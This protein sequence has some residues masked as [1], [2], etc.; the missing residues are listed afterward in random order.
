MGGGAALLGATAV[1]RIGAA[2]PSEKGRAFTFAVLNP[3][4]M[5][6]GA[7][8]CVVMLTPGGKCYLWDT[9]NGCP[10]TNKVKN[11]G[12]DIVVPWL[13]AHG[14]KAIDGLIISHYHADH[15]GGFLWM[16]DHFP[17]RKVFD[18]SFVPTDGKPLREHDAVELARAKDALA[19]WEKAHP[20]M[21]VTN[22][23]SSTDLGWDEPGEKFE[24]VWPPK[25][26]PVGLLAH[27][28]KSSA[29]DFPFH[30]LLNANSTGLRVTVGKRTFFI[31]GD[32]QEQYIT[33]YMRPYLEKRNQWNCDVLVLPGHG[34]PRNSGDVLAMNPRPKIA[35]G[36]IGN[37]PWMIASGKASQRTFSQAGI[38]T[39]TTNIHGDIVV[40]TDG[41]GLSVHTDPSK[42]HTY[43]PSGA[44]GVRM[45]PCG[46]A[47][48]VTVQAPPGY[49]SWPMIQAAGDRVVC[50]YSRG[51]A[52]TT[53]EGKRDTYART[54]LDGGRTWGPETCIAGDPA[55]GDAV[56]GRGVDENGALLFWVGR[57][58]ARGGH[59]LY[60]TTDGVTFEKIASLP[61]KS[62]SPMP[63]QVMDV[64]RIPGKGLASPW[65]A[66]NYKNPESGHS[67]GLLASTDNGHTWT[68]RTVE[69]NLAKRDWP[70]ELSAVS[71]GGGR[72]LVL[73]R[74]EG[75]GAQ[76]QITSTDNG[77]T[78]R[79]RKT[80][81]TDVRESTPSLIFDPKTGLVSNYYY[82]RG[83]KKLKRRVAD[84]AFIFDRPE[85]W[86]EPDVLA[87]GGEARSYDAGNVKA[88]VSG[89]RHLI[90]LYSGTKSDCAVFV[91]SVPAPKTI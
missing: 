22:T 77:A 72:I 44:E 11:N 78:W 54:S 88:T 91:V 83:A 12:K 18:N 55:I 21:L 63:I 2:E 68:Q 66:G 24:V 60:R 16:H 89:D 20:G 3:D 85:S 73:A 28:R 6:G 61:A 58:G 39:Y 64:F 5:A 48:V 7:G 82:Q 14:V 34:N 67:W 32:I 74:S 15:F 31:A 53:H 51:T 33:D 52:H 62:F 45:V 69:E 26:G 46:N 43:D 41:D 90:A 79:R 70:T 80:N 81:I 1:S 8:Q 75:T 35:I 10:H 57:F 37:V 29:T 9:A 23:N 50:A 56:E 65:F 87:E 38:E 49:N 40:T 86:P 13:K 36:S 30:H 17:I 25:E 71:L 4:C 76:F 47:Q 19:A 27:F 59:D 42:L 84:A